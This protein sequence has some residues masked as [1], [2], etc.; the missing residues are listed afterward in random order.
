VNSTGSKVQYLHLLP[1]AD[2]PEFSAADPF[3]AIVIVEQ[4]IEAERR[5]TICRWLAGTGCLYMMAWGRNCGDWVTA[6]ELA[7]RAKLA[8]DEDIPSEQLTIATA[9]ENEALKDV[10]WFAKFTAMHPCHALDNTIVLHLA[11]TAT[12]EELIA[13]YTAA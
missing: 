11:A 3:K 2:M 9:H 1:A 10:L 8:D 7:N 13:A 5:D 4:P 12:E 6:M